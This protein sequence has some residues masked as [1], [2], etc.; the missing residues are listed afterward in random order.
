[1]CMN[2]ESISQQL[3]ALSEQLSE[4]LAQKEREEKF[5]IEAN[6]RFIKNQQCF[7]KYYPDIASAIKNYQ[8]RDEFCIHVTHSGHG[9]FVP[10][11]FSA[12]IYAQ[13]QSPI[14]QTQRQIQKQVDNPVF[15]LTD[16]TG[17]GQNQE[18]E[19][20]H[21]KYM[22]ELTNLMVN[23]R[24]KNKA[25]IKR[26]PDSFPSAIIFGIGLG[27]HVPL[28]L[29]HTQF[30]YTFLIEPDFEQFFA[31]LFC[32][33]WYE[34]IPK[35]DEQGGCLFFHLG[36]DH[37][38]FIQDIEKV[39]DAVGAFALV[40]SF[41]YQHT[42]G[43]ELNTLI[44]KW[45]S[46]YFR[47]QFGHGFYND[48][49]TGFSHS[50]HH[51]KNK[52]NWLTSNSTGV[53]KETPVFIIG[54]GPSLDEAD[55][56]LK[57]NHDKAIVVA[58]GTAIASLYKKGIP[59]DFHVLVER[60]YSNYKIFGDIVPP[61]VYKNTNLIGLNTLYPDT[62]RRYKWSGIMAKGSEAGTSL[63]NVLAL[64]HLSQG[65]PN[66]PY[67][68]PVVANAALSAV[69]YLGFRNVYLFGIDN[70]KAPGG[71][72]HSKDSIYKPSNDDDSEG[73]H[74]LEIEGHT[75]PANF[76]GYVLS[77]DLFM[78]AHTQLEKLLKYYH[79]ETCFN[80]GSGAKIDKAISVQAEDLLDLE[81]D[82]DKNDVVEK[83]KLNCFKQF[84]LEDVPDSDIALDALK[85]ITDHIIKIA[86]ES[87]ENRKQ[88]SAQLRRQA[89]YLYTYKDSL[90][91]H[92]FHVFRGSLLYYHCPLIT[93]LYTYED[94]EFSLAQY[95]RLNEL[96]MRYVK[97]IYAHFSENYTEK[98][99]LGLE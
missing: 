64:K 98:C 21:V 2:K 75:L 27:Y 16:Y 95:K 88:A 8:V 70:G 57:R 84:P 60:P 12:P 32:T 90:L 68:N 18:D 28:L 91:G 87:V 35:I 72:H 6:E 34:L 7:E 62:N 19:R 67:C 26:L 5:A 40:R 56:F 86:S 33:D 73:L 65:L 30:E 61:D 53:D 43:S 11:G 93:L 80:V 52:A 99:D 42:P 39:S 20:L 83:I 82:F 50:I 13:S 31:S 77:N 4:N 79:F 85:E 25:Y 81:S 14:E 29:E 38:S 58:A 51:I 36:V 74:H 37:T 63:V 49:V 1:M 78:I 94:E 10:N 96:W 24:E 92:L 66:P 89:R 47:F 71:G 76:G 59:V 97:E 22:T 15:S 41:C 55:E 3:D 48:A 17:Y 44:K 45:V 69:L 9:N 54:N 23:I 46:D